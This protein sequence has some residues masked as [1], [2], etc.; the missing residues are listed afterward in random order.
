MTQIR[1]KTPI[2]DP[3]TGLIKLRVGDIGDV[4]DFSITD[5]KENYV[6]IRSQP[7]NQIDRR[8]KVEAEFENGIFD[9]LYPDQFD[10]V[11]YIGLLQTIMAGARILEVL[12]VSPT[13]TFRSNVTRPF[14]QTFV[15]DN[16]LK[17]TIIV[18]MQ[19]GLSDVEIIYEGI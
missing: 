15:L 19:S 18:D 10:F 2:V 14:A 4:R 9:L 5:G 8:L 16:S 11:E 13:P 6:M 1:V 17:V 3:T 7:E 12:N